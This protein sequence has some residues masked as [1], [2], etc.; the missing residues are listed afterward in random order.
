MD[1]KDKTL[2]IEI[3]QVDHVKRFGYYSNNIKEISEQKCY[4]LRNWG[5]VLTSFF[6]KNGSK[7][8]RRGSR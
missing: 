8:I 7:G 1:G 3:D 6:G 2:S 5:H 4:L